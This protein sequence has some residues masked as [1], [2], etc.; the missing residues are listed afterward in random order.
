MRNRNEDR[1]R[2]AVPPT[3]PT[4]LAPHFPANSSLWLTWQIASLSWCQKHVKHVR[5]TLIHCLEIRLEI[6]EH[7]VS[8]TENIR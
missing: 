5:I 6:L 1:Q 2:S 4:P 7:F 3:P 8:R